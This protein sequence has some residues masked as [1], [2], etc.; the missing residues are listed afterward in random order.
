MY[1]MLVYT[2]KLSRKMERDDSEVNYGDLNPAVFRRGEPWTADVKAM[3][4]KPFPFSPKKSLLEVDNVFRDAIDC[5][6]IKVGKVLNNRFDFPVVHIQK[7]GRDLLEKTMFV[8]PKGLFFAWARKNDSVINLFNIAVGIIFGAIIGNI[9]KLAA[10]Y[11][12]LS[13]HTK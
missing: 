2:E 4:K 1:R 10:I 7:S 9:D 6:Y 5:D 8:F 11:S 13:S 12:F 3:Y